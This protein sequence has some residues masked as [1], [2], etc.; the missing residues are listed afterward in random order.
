MRV[1]VTGGRDFADMD[2][3]NRV[4]LVLAQWD[5]DGIEA[6][7]HGG[8]SGADALADAFCK[9]CGVPV[10]V[11]PADWDAHG[12]AA[13]P[14]R[15]QRMLDTFKPELV[16][17]FAGGKGTMNCVK[18]ARKRKIPV[19]HPRMIVEEDGSRRIRLEDWG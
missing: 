7:A 19:I 13:G 15:N 18:E 4:L 2:L 10:D 8:A 12:K 16:V 1:V 11:F 6:L 5:P 17:A 9:R 14:L 3:V